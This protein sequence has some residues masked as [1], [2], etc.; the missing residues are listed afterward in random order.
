MPEPV[1]SSTQ[2]KYQ[3]VGTC[4]RCDK[5]SKQYELEQMKFDITICPEC[6]KYICKING[7]LIHDV[8]LE[9]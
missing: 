4:S 7:F 1:E 2:E 8:V 9:S 5:T 3:F 6:Y